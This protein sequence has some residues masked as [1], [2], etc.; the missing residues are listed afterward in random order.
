MLARGIGEY[1]KTKDDLIEDAWMD[2]E[3]PG[4]QNE[5]RK[6]KAQA[7]LN[8]LMTDPDDPISGY[9]PDK[10]LQAYNEIASMTP[11]IAEQPAALR[12][13][14]R[15]R[16]Q[17]HQEPFEAKEMTDIEKGLSA[18]RQGTPSTNLLSDSPEMLRG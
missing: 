15:R 6:I 2:L 16:L 9:E 8:Q 18:S 5:I 1:P 13:L 14:L 12:P 7:M 3:D 4:H 11:R 10:V 17:G